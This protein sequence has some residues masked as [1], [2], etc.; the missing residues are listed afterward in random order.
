MLA[1]TEDR[2]FLPLSIAAA[3]AITMSLFAYS[4]HVP[5]EIAAHGIDKLLHAAM[6]FTLTLC[7]GR[8]LRGRIALAASLVFAVFAVDEFLQRFSASRTSDWGDLLADGVGSTLAIAAWMK[9]RS[10]LARPPSS[11]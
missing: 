11:P 7:L 3:L 5:P 9:V 4:G 2:R 8:A 10:S 1:A 6:T